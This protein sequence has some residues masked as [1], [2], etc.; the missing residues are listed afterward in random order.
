MANRTQEHEDLRQTAWGVG[1]KVWQAGAAIRAIACIVDEYETEVGAEN[2]RDLL[3]GVQLLGDYLKEL[4]H[5]L[6]G[7]AYPEPASAEEASQ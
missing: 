5:Q 3:Q 7:P 2:V 6:T 4:A 1:N